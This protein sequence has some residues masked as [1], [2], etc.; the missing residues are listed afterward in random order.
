MAPHYR[1]KACLNLLSALTPER[2]AGPAGVAVVLSTDG[3]TP[4]EHHV[5]GLGIRRSGRAVCTCA[6]E[7]NLRCLEGSPEGPQP[8]G[9][10]PAA[11][12]RCSGG[13]HVRPFDLCRVLQTFEGRPREARKGSRHADAAR[14]DPARDVRVEDS[15]CVC[16]GRL[17]AAWQ[18]RFALP[19]ATRRYGGGLET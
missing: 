16:G 3:G 15:G 2:V 12:V 9:H 5:A 11:A 10:G 1:P 19:G 18:C 13:R 4:E 7:R 17:S 14:R 8:P 6:R